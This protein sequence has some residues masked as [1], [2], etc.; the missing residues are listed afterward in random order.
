MDKIVKGIV[1]KAKDYKE[2]DKL[3][4]LLTLEEG[5]IVVRARGVKKATSK[6]KAFCQVFCFGEFELVNGKPF[7]ILS[8][9]KTFDNFYSLTTDYD[10]FVLSS[11]VPLL[12]DKI[13]VENTMYSNL[14]LSAIK[15]LSLVNLDAVS[16]HLALAKFFLD[17]LYYEGVS[18]DFSQ[19]SSCGDALNNKIFLDLDSG[20]FVRGSCLSTGNFVEI[21]L[22]MLSGLKMINDTSFDKLQTIKLNK[23]LLEKI[24]VVL[25][26]DIAN[27]FDINYNL[28]KF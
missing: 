21:T 1:L 15:T 14:F 24:F 9:V 25:L 19:C 4:T 10:K 11:L 17:T 2:N 28:L 12:L 20:E 27:R 5:K 8:G 26:K 22:G 7:F 18:F 6:L 3:L 16:P 13:C 23:T